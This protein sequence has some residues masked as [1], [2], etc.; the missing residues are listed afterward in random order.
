M[1]LDYIIL[2]F[3]NQIHQLFNEFE[4]L[5]KDRLLAINQSN[6]YFKDR[7]LAD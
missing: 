6:N 5:I 7:V 4:K 2:K 3:I 1:C